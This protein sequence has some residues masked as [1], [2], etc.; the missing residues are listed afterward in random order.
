MRTAVAALVAVG[1]LVLGT[2]AAAAAEQTAAP[3]AEAQQSSTRGDVGTQ[4]WIHWDTYPGGPA[5]LLACHVRGKQ[6]LKN[7][8]WHKY[9]CV[10][11]GVV[12]FLDVD[13]S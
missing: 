11:W 8:D 1:G 5:G 12:I 6:G 2:G 3:A 10:N 7:G 9:R 4:G 13:Y